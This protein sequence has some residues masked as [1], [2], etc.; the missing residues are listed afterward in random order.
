MADTPP[1][2]AKSKAA[3]K[4]KS[5]A[6]MAEATVAAPADAPSPP[7]IK[8]GV[9]VGSAALVAALL[10]ATRSKGTNWTKS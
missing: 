7:W 2:P 4:V 10:Y 3:P 9:G 5:G 8:I 1:K 6:D